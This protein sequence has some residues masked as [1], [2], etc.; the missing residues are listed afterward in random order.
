[1]PSRFANVI[2]DFSRVQYL[3]TWGSCVYQ[4]KDI[5]RVSSVTVVAV[6]LQL[7]NPCQETTSIG[8]CY[9]A[10]PHSRQQLPVVSVPQ[11]PVEIEDPIPLEYPDEDWDLLRNSQTLPDILQTLSQVANRVSRYAN[12]LS[13]TTN[14]GSTRTPRQPTQLATNFTS[15]LGQTEDLKLSDFCQ[16]VRDNPTHANAN[17]VS[18]T[19]YKDLKGVPHE[20]LVAHVRTP[21]APDMWIRLER[22]ADFAHPSSWMSR[23]CP[24]SSNY[25]AD[26]KVRISADESDLMSRS[27]GIS[28]MEKLIFKGD[29][30]SLRSFAV[31]LEI[32]RSESGAYTLRKPKSPTYLNGAR[33]KFRLKQ[34][35]RRLK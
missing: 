12:A 5:T 3:A 25:A 7:T 10:S 4:E 18:L 15:A 33:K 30:L 14:G 22:A 1:M 34:L 2:K 11:S 20:F 16:R 26:D 21:D 29:K 8:H 6:V 13:A 19:C 23:L 27:G 32:F 17:V 31:L 24:I 35:D 9:A 28:P